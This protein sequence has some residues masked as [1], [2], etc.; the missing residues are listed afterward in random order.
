[1][2]ESEFANFNVTFRMATLMCMSELMS[3][4]SSDQSAGELVRGMN[5]L[6]KN[7]GIC[8]VRSLLKKLNKKSTAFR[9]KSNAKSSTRSLEKVSSN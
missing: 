1:V 2:K 4:L 6:K 7:Y 5:N 3:L 8:C 9:S